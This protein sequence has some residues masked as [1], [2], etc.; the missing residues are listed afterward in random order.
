MHKKLLLK[1]LRLSR[2]PIHPTHNPYH[3]LKS[4]PLCRKMFNNQLRLR[5]NNLHRL[6]PSNLHKPSPNNPHRQSPKN[7]LKRQLPLPKTHNQ[8]PRSKISISYSLRSKR[9]KTRIKKRNQEC[10]LNSHQASWASTETN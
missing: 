9:S 2:K 8:V 1:I 5:L 4:K 3:K 6:C 7:L 10:F